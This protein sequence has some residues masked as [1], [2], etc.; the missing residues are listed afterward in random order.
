MIDIRLLNVDYNANMQI[1]KEF[2]NNITF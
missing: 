1:I 2:Y